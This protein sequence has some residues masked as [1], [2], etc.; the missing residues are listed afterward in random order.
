MAGLGDIFGKGGIAEQIFI[1]GV[2]NQVISALANPYFTELTQLVNAKNPDVVLDPA[3]LA[4]LVVRDFMGDADAKAEAAKSGIDADRF[5]KLVQLAKPRTSP[6]DL[7]Q[8]VT[9]NFIT[10]DQGAR[11]AADSG[12][13]ADEFGDMVTLSGLPPDPTAL[14]EALRRGIIPEDGPPDGVSF[15][16]GMKEGPTYNKYIPMIKALAVQE[17]TPA[18]ALDALL[19]GQISEDQGKAL[20]ERFGGDPQYFTMLFDTRGSAPTPLEAIEMAQRG[21]IPWD[22][23]GPDVTSYQQA[24]LEGPWRNKWSGPYRALADYVPPPRTVT[25]MLKTGSLTTDQAAALL[26]KSGLTPELAQAYI[27][28]A[29]QQSATS[30]L[31]LTLTDI[32]DLYSAN[33]LPHDQTLAMV[34]ALGYSQE[35]AERLIELRQLRLAIAQ[36]NSAVSRIRTLYTGRKITRATAQSVLDALDVPADQVTDILQTWD[37][38]VAANVAQLTE[39]QIVNA[40]SLDLITGD[41]ASNELQA[42]GYTARDAWILLSIKNGKGLPD[43]PPAGPNPVG[44]IP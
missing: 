34:A 1:W 41:E 35:N 11:L 42:L 19:E 39:S 17:P 24:F 18:D 36:V 8:L 33:I 10:Q 25:A 21:V 16:Q 4:Q 6:A 2:L 9:R 13:T 27:T 3:S 32:L 7:A 28:D 12:L 26:A 43:R 23:V 44:P 15:T 14:A 30:E 40:W 38:E 5:A 22:G 20:Y 29:Q 37:L 31:D